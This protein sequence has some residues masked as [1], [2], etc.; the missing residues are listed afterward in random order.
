MAQNI[1]VL[2]YPAKDLEAAK[3]F[4]NT[5]LGVKPYADAPYYVGYKVGDLEVGLDPNGQ[6]VIAYIEVRDIKSSMQTLLDSGATMH[7]DAK[8]VG[9]G[10][11]IAQVKDKNGNILGLRQFPK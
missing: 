4:F 5:F 7:Q 8:D 1:K 11:L 6:A 2:V 10:L 3:T 9:G